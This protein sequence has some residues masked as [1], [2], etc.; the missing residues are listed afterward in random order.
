MNKKDKLFVIVMLSIIGFSF[1]TVIFA[2][3]YQDVLEER[4]QQ[5]LLTI[6]NV[7]YHGAELIE[8]QD[9]FYWLFPSSTIQV[10]NLW[11]F[12][13]LIGNLG[14]KKVYYNNGTNW[15]S[16]FGFIIADNVSVYSVYDIAIIYMVNGTEWSFR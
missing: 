10:D 13:A 2:K 16:V 11:K 12:Q 15:N 5:T 7:R 6:G 3:R 8:S 14:I 1:L 4:Y 9:F